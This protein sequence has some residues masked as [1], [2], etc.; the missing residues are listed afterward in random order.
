MLFHFM[1]QLKFYMLKASKIRKHHEANYKNRNVIRFAD[2]MFFWEDKGRLI[3]RLEASIKKD[4]KTYFY[5]AYEAKNIIKMCK[6]VHYKA[7]VECL[8][9]CDED[10]YIKILTY[11]S[12][13]KRFRVEREFFVHRDFA[14]NDDLDA[15]E[16]FYYVDGI[17]YNNYQSYVLQERGTERGDLSVDITSE[18]FSESTTRFPLCSVDYIITQLQ[19][20]SEEAKS[21]QLLLVPPL[22]S[23]RIKTSAEEFDIKPVEYFLQSDNSFVIKVIILSMT[24][25][26]IK[27]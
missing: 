15:L 23:S 11:D 21:C 8:M 17:L 4:E 12:I 7:G 13:N 18:H 20:T 19:Y 22:N 1:N 14:T 24:K 6:K 2:R 9:I 5:K 26:V 25:Y 10:K 3:E 27:L 16:H